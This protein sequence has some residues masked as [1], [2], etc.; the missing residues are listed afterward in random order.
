[1]K[2]VR[3]VAITDSEFVSSTLT[4]A[5]HSAWSSA[6]TYA[7]A[8]RVIHEHYIYESLQGSNTNHTPTGETSDAWWLEIGPTNR[9]AM[10]DQQINTGS[11]DSSPITVVVAPG[12]INSVVLLDVEADTATVTMHDGATEVFTSTVRLVES[13]IAT[14]TDYFFEP[15]TYAT[16]KIIDGLPY[17]LNGQVTVTVTKTSGT[18]RVGGVVFGNSFEIGDVLTGARAGITSYSR[19]EQNTFGVTQIVRRLSAK[20]MSLNLKLDTSSFKRVHALLTELDSVPCVWVAEPDYSDKYA[21][22]T[23]FGYARDFQ[24][25]VPGPVFCYCSLEIQGMI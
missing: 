4:E 8:A 20:R 18:A 12:Y 3:P 2:V 10:F 25:E 13:N 7:L 1:M 22:L 17:Y 14:W 16:Q 24:I 9:W 23:I 6:T 21:P 19:I 15:F 11:S 5:E